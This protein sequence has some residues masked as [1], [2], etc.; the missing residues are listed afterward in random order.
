L[1]GDVLADLETF[2]IDRRANHAAKSLGLSPKTDHGTHGGR[3]HPCDQPSPAG[4]R[5]P[6]DTGVSVD[7]DHRGTVGHH[8]AEAESSGGGDDCISPGERV[9]DHLRSSTA[10]SVAHDGHT[11][12]V[13]L[14]HEHQVIESDLSAGGH[15][16]PVLDHGLIVITDVET[17][18]ERGIGTFRDPAIPGGYESLSTRSIEMVQHHDGGFAV[19]AACAHVRH[20]HI[21]DKAQ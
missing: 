5:Q 3:Q 1:L 14:I 6:K 15:P 8:D 16:S 21:Q 19:E 9:L 4:V 7:K 20:R 10:L 2:E 13:N 12:S 17:K 18:I 11:R